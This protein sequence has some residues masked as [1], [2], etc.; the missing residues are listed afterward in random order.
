MGWGEVGGR[1]GLGFPARPGGRRKGRRATERVV[2]ATSGRRRW[3]RRA[4]LRRA[5]PGLHRHCRP[6]AGTQGGGRAC[7]RLRR[8]SRVALDPPDKAGD[9]DGKGGGRRKGLC[10]ALGRRRWVRRALLRSAHSTLR[11]H[12]RPCAGNPGAAGETC[13]CSAHIAV[14]LDPA[15]KPGMTTERLLDATG[16]VEV[17]ATL[18]TRMLPPLAPPLTA[19][20][21]V[22]CGQSRAKGLRPWVPG[23]RPGRTTERVEDDEEVCACDLRAVITAAQGRSLRLPVAGARPPTAS[24][25]AL[26]G[27]FRA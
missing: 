20:S 22:S 14:A 27:Q 17:R 6:C 16:G 3:V 7:S 10:V 5:H 26:C 2:R 11:R 15:H 9:D 25:P 24:L 19:S 12:C 18:A 23:T 1:G 4:L 21:P 8:I 13:A